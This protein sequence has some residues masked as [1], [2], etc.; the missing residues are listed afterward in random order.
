MR[1]V[2]LLVHEQKKTTNKTKKNLRK[3]GPIDESIQIKNKNIQRH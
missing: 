3:E 2:I 1:T